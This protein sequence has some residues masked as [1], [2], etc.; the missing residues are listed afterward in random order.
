MTTA[1]KQVEN[2]L[3]ISEEKLTDIAVKSWIFAHGWASLVATGIIVYN[4]EK[5][6]TMLY[7][8]FTDSNGI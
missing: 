2:M 4:E 3:D 6:E 1:M 8:F 5:V 7:S